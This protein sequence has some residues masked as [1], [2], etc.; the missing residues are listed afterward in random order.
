MR[1]WGRIRTPAYGL[2][3]PLLSIS[4]TRQDGQ[5]IE[6]RLGQIGDTDDYTLK[7]STRAEYLRLPGYTAQP[8]LDAAAR[9]ALLETA[10]AKPAPKTT[11][12][13]IDT[14]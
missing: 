10:G 7:A 13:E 5:Q 6:Y 14:R 4:L 12:P 9:D 2:D 1:S 3:E 11:P 8:L